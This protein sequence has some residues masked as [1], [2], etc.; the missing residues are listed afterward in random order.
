MSIHFVPSYT[1]QIMLVT[2]CC[3]LVKQL[4]GCRLKNTGFNLKLYCQI[5]RFILS[6]N[7]FLPSE[8]S[9][10]HTVQNGRYCI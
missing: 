6:K 2:I 10:D 3:F 4:P 5:S 7:C 8:L 1:L 9:G